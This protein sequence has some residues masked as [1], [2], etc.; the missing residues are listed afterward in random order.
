MTFA[1]L[2]LSQLVHAFNLRSDRSLFQLGLFG[3]MKLIG[4][5]II[6]CTM[7][8]SVISLPLLSSVFK[9]V[10]LSPTQWLIVAAMSLVPLAVSETEKKLGSKNQKRS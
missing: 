6:G 9:T 7:Q 8:I 4:A 5:F 2:S 10:P 3:N 1:V